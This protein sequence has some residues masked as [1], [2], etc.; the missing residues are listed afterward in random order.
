MIQVVFCISRGNLIWS[1]SYLY[2]PM[3]LK[4]N[5]SITL[6]F[7]V[8]SMLS[9]FELASWYLVFH[10]DRGPSMTGFKIVSKWCF[11][12]VQ[13]GV[14]PSWNFTP[15]MS[16]SSSVLASKVKLKSWILPYF[17]QKSRSN[18]LFCLWVYLEHIV[19]IYPWCFEG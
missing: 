16:L 8:S 10:W 17:L 14:F 11:S 1:C 13:H 6:I 18:I 3:M 4:T 9:C 19:C 5:T 15:K 12:S 7:Y 2:L